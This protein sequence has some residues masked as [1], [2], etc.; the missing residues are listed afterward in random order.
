[1]QVLKIEVIMTFTIKFFIFV[2]HFWQYCCYL[3]LLSY[4][5][6]F[7]LFSLKLPNHLLHYWNNFW[8]NLYNIFCVAFIFFELSS[9]GYSK[10]IKIIHLYKVSQRCPIKRL[11][12]N[13]LFHKF[14]FNRNFEWKNRYY[15]SQFYLF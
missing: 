10:T 14:L 9:I 2:F 3:L 6:C 4:F 5:F 11:F 12:K 13:K 8:L 15:L 7:I 1:M